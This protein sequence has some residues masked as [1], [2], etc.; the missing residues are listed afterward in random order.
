[1][2]R[3]RKKRSLV[4]LISVGAH[5]LVGGALALIPQE[6]LREVVGIA[7]ADAPKPKP[8]APKPESHPAKNPAPRAVRA[9]PASPAQAP[10]ADPASNGQTP[11]AFAN[12]GISLDSSSSDG[13]AVPIAA[14]MAPQPL[15]SA[16]APK[17]PK[18]FVATQS[19]C[20]EDIKKAVP[21]RVVK[22]EYSNEARLAEVEGRIRLE[23]SIDENGFV[24]DVKML[25]G[26]GHGLDEQAKS[27]ALKMHFKPATLCGKPVPS[28]F[29]LAMR[30]AL[31]S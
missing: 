9:A 5:L 2:A 28:S 20:D 10:A 8:A 24:T 15:L 7:F 4:F 14:R 22:A 30:F 31:G 16:V 21:D 6:K 17:V 1:M 27:A 26:L 11:N 19:R 13:I 23:L 18:V 25:S 3:A 12:L 29:I